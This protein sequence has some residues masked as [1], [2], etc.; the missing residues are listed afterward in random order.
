MYELID[1]ANPLP[2]SPPHSTTFKPPF[3]TSTLPLSL[4]PLFRLPPTQLH[5]FL[6]ILSGSCETTRD[7]GTFTHLLVTAITDIAGIRSKAP[8]AAEFIIDKTTNYPKP[9][10]GYT[11]S[12]LLLPPHDTDND[13]SVEGDEGE[14]MG[15]LKLV[16][17]ATL[18]QITTLA[19]DEGWAKS[20][21]EKWRKGFKDIMGDHGNEGVGEAILELL[22]KASGAGAGAGGG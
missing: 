20:Q 18:V 22:D 5:Q 6:S 14:R 3:H 13:E 9:S 19:D 2:L 17:V 4:L 12:L 21:D 10:V 1:T 16:L 7:K 8:K 15:I 11:L